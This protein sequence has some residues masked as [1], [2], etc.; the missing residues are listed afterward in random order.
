MPQRDAFPHPP[1]GARISTRFFPLSEA[2]RPYI[3]TIYLSEV[4][5]PDGS[6]VEDY[7]HPEW[8]N[9]RFV[10]G[11]LPLAAIGGGPVVETPRFVATGPT[12]GPPP[13]C[14]MQNVLCRLRCETSPP[15]SP[16]R[17]KPTRAL[18]LAPSM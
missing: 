3:S 13:P 8:A 14:G 10:E 9:L 15:T 1:T 11:D 16:N 7:L 6:R 12:P 17:P 4:T 18:R 5:V 2:L